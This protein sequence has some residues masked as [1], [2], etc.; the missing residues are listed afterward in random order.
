MAR[1]I[2]YHLY[3]DEICED[4]N[5]RVSCCTWNVNGG[6]RSPRIN[7]QLG[8]QLIGKWLLGKVRRARVIA[9]FPADQPEDLELIEGIFFQI[10]LRK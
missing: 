8:E 5:L 4:L 9:N 3:L 6:S 2:F 1:L 10:Q 7:D